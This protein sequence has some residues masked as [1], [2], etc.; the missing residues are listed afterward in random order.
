MKKNFQ[1][2]TLL[3]S[4]LLTSTVLPAQS[5]F[6]TNEKYAQN[7]LSL[8]LG[9]QWNQAQDLVF[10]PLIYSGSSLSNLTL[11][12]ERYQK[13]GIHQLS[14]GYNQSDIR[15]APL[16]TFTDFGQ[17]FTRIPSIL[18]QVNLS[19]GYAHLVKRTDSF[20]W[21]VGGIV[22]TQLHHTTYNFGLSDD[23]GYLFTNDLQAWLM[24][25]LQLDSKNRIRF[26][27]SIPLLTYAT[28]PEYAIVDNEEIQ[29]NG[30]SLAFLYQQGEWASLNNYL[31]MDFGLTLD[32]RISN[33][34]AIQ[35]GY[36]LAYYRYEQPLSISI[37]KNQFNLGLS[38]TF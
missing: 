23:E 38:F 2:L 20:Q 19:Y 35:V 8:Q 21:Y 7:S 5:N 17:S 28:R 9:W 13:R 37:L 18:R 24:A 29:H 12:Y 16:I 26:D 3:G 6:F 15:A 34:A 14:L 4:L 10:S 1:L 32:H 33:T 36:G 31:A 27:L 25:F 30:S 22:E 11:Q